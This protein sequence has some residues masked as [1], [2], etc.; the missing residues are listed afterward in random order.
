MVWLWAAQQV[1]SATSCA[2]ESPHW[3][4]PW[5]LSSPPVFF[6][7]SPSF[8]FLKLFLKSRI[9]RSILS[10]NYFEEKSN[11][12][13]KHTR[14]RIRAQFQ[15]E[16]KRRRNGPVRLTPASNWWSSRRSSRWRNTCAGRAGSN[17][18][19]RCPWP[20]ARSRFGFKIDAW[21]TRRS[22]NKRGRTIPFNETEK[23]VDRTQAAIHRCK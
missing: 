7:T 13:H 19:S 9:N 1:T 10:R 6:Q 22:S 11:I 14:T 16:I 8:F 21:S 18:R 23:R 20:S 12:T 2:D 17:W 5:H 15:V 4:T 3:A